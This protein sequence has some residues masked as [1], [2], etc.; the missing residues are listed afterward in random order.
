MTDELLLTPREKA[1]IFKGYGQEC[2]SNMSNVVDSTA[3]AQLAKAKPFIEKLEAQIKEDIWLVTELR[4]AL[5]Q[6]DIDI[7]EAKREERERILSKLAEY[8]G[9]HQGGLF[10]IGIPIKEWQALKGEK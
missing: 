1:K 3:K 5:A 8:G 4:N 9:A 2:F 6:K 7:K 10:V